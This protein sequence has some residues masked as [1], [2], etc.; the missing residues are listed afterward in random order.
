MTCLST[1]LTNWVEESDREC[2]MDNIIG[3]GKSGI[4]PAV[5]KCAKEAKLPLNKLKSCYNKNGRNLLRC[6]VAQ[7][8]RENATISAT[9]KLDGHPWIVRDD[10]QWKDWVYGP[11]C[12]DQI[13][14]QFLVDDILS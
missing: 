12:N 7:S 10:N 14:R 8:F 2:S 13:I 4:Q 9:I 3:S 11:A 6:S 5:E 1:V